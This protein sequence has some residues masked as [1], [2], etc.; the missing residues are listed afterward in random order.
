MPPKRINWVE[1]ITSKAN[2]NVLISEDSES[3]F[4]SMNKCKIKSTPIQLMNSQ[5]RKFDIPIRMSALEDSSSVSISEENKEKN[6]YTKMMKIC[7]PLSKGWTKRIQKRKYSNKKELEGFKEFAV[8][9]FPKI[10]TSKYSS[11]K[12]ICPSSQFILTQKM[13]HPNHIQD[14]VNEVRN[15]KIMK[16]KDSEYWKDEFKILDIME[17]KSPK[18]SSWGQFLL[19]I[20][21]S[22]F[23][24]ST[25][26]KLNH[27]KNLQNFFNNLLGN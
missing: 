13:K 27:Q 8:S 21:K 26:S 7:K 17:L 3:P 18:N 1:I 19:N 22:P 16:N 23:R 25:K 24:S 6:G 9:V 10:S 14:R 15:Q 4:P 5:T 2:K 20:Q 11:C 12:N